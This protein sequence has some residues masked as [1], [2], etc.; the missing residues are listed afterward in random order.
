MKPHP[1]LLLA[2]AACGHS[3]P[4]LAPHDRRD[5]LPA[6]LPVVE[7]DIDLVTLPVSKPAKNGKGRGRGRG[8]RGLPV[9][10][11]LDM[12][13]VTLPV[14]RK[15]ARQFLNLDIDVPSLH[16]SGP[17]SK[18]G[19]QARRDVGRKEARQFLNEDIGVPS[20]HSTG[21]GSKRG[22]ETRGDLAGGQTPGHKER[23]QFL[24]EDLEI[25][26]LHSS[27]PGSKRAAD[28]ERLAARAHARNKARQFHNDDISDI[29]SI[30][31]TGPSRSR[32]A[33]KMQLP[34]DED[35]DMSSLTL[36]VSHRG[37]VSA[38]GASRKAARQFLNDDS[39]EIP[40]IHSTGPSREKRARMK[41]PVDEEL[42]MSTMTLP[43][44]T[45]TRDLS[46]EDKH[47]ARQLGEDAGSSGVLSLQVLH[48]TNPA[49][50]KRAIEVELANRSDVAYYAQREPLPLF[51]TIPS[52]KK[53]TNTHSEPRNPSPARLRPA[54]HGLLR[55]VGQP[56]LHHP[57]GARRHLLRGGGQLRHS[58]VVHLDRD[59]GQPDAAV[60]H[61]GG[62]HH[63]RP[64]L[65]R[66]ARE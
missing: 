65:D 38:R 39:A 3:W 51:P 7:D 8:K 56:G 13:D 29:P 5:A 64:G 6:R 46:G 66:A 50:F 34:V 58:A 11:E 4:Q 59:G 18:R 17:G 14:A 40:S 16:S 44:S 20:I 33:P 21:P 36:P 1:L 24:N 63:L 61:R 49:L 55:A 9:N 45:R 2:L 32:R 52:P 19:V 62:E 27:G 25:P 43:V 42:D 54:G 47:E 57:P 10:E 37:R 31:S 26:S 15:E 30:H 23:R 60:W 41:L 53:A 35:L 28:A 48:S 22:V 12:S